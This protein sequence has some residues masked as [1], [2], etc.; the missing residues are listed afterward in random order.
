MVTIIYQLCPFLSFCRLKFHLNQKLL[1][2]VNQVSHQNLISQVSEID[3]CSYRIYLI[4][5][6]DIIGKLSIDDLQK[7]QDSTW[8]VRAKWFNIGLA[9][10][11]S[12]GT[13]DA[14]KKTHQSDCDDCYTS[15]MKIWLRGVDP[16]PT[17]AALSDALKSTS[18]GCGHLAE[19]LVR[20]KQ[21]ES[22]GI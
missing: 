12:A 9:L 22:F 11:I 2:Y 18:V 17:W 13:L 14:V 16:H 1:P 10:G 5:T 6:Y 15:V 19:Q 8:D 4:S 3:G 20:S 7:V 21:L